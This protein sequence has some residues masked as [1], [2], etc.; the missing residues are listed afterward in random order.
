MDEHLSKSLATAHQNWD[1]RWKDAAVRAAWDEPGAL[2]QALLP[3]MRERG[4]RRV[5]DLGCGIGRHAHY[6][7]AQGFQCVGVDASDAGLSYARE[8]A[9]ADGLTIDYQTGTFYDLPFGEGSFDVV[10]AWNVLYHGDGDVAARGID[11]I[12]RVLVPGGLYVG[13]MLST[14]NAGYG[15]GREVRPGTFVVDGDPGDKGHPHFYCD[16]QTLVALHRGFEI[17]DVR[18]HEQ[19]P[20]A[21]HWEFT[22]ERRSIA[23]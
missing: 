2:V 5:L 19:A 3:R 22:M 10:I 7:A 8:R 18:D 13:S 23:E 9:A 15:R 4:L 20:G 17:F 1:E 6:L 21:Y 12:R 11:G 14:R 16:G